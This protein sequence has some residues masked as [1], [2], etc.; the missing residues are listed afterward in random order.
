M[1]RATRDKFASGTDQSS[2]TAGNS[3]WETA[4]LIFEALNRDFGPF[5]IDLCADAKRYLRTIWFGPGSLV[6]EF[7]ALTA[8][9]YI[10]GENGYGNPPY[11]K[12]V[13]DYLAVAR[14]M[15]GGPYGMRSTHLLPMRVTKAFR[16]FVLDG[17]SDLIFPTSRLV[18][19]EDGVPRINQKTFVEEG[20][21]VADCALFDSI[22]VR[23]TPGHVGPPKISEW[24]VPKHVTPED[25]ARAFARK[26][27]QQVS[28][29]DLHV[30]SGVE[31]NAASQAPPP[32]SLDTNT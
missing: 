11:G 2:L 30:R 23:Y 15:A 7:D 6:G 25:L 32:L 29:E 10:Y 8:L 21:A 26:Q 17:A 20:R 14:A 13:A 5:D 24:A 9:W 28:S 4:P 12:F 22:I 1:N 19:F 16:R 18:F 27:H 3:C 31:A